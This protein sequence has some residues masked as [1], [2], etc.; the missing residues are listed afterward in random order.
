MAHRSVLSP[1]TLRSLAPPSPQRFVDSDSPRSH[2]NYK[3]SR[4]FPVWA[5]GLPRVAWPHSALGG[6]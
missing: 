6:S 1:A 4:N 5:L 2:P 3:Y